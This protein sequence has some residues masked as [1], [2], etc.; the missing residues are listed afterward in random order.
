MTRRWIVRPLRRPILAT[1]R[2]GTR[3]SNAGWVHGF[4]ML[5]ITS[6]IGFGKPRCNSLPLSVGVRR[7]LLQTFPYTV[8]FRETEQRS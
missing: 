8:Y 6:S 3:A 1:P 4:S 5:S 2:R 7:A